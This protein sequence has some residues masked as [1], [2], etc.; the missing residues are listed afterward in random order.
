M[1][2]FSRPWAEKNVTISDKRDKNN[3]EKEPMWKGDPLKRQE[4]ASVLNKKAQTVL[5]KWK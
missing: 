1:M 3:V 4:T 2:T 5:E